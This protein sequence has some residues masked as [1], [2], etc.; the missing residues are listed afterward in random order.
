MQQ[1]PR[2]STRRSRRASLA[3][4]VA[5]VTAFGTAGLAM[6][7][8][9]GAATPLRRRRGRTGGGDRAGSPR[10]HVPLRPGPQGLPRHRPEPHLE[11]LVH[12]RGRRPVGRVLPDRGQHQR[13]DAAVRRHRRLDVH[14]RPDPRHDVHRP[15]PRP[16]RHG[17]PRRQH[18]EERPLPPRHRLHHRPT[19]EQRG[20]AD[21]APPREPPRPAGRLRPVRRD[22]QRQR[23]RRGP[24]HAERRRGHGSRRH[25]HRAP[26]ARLVRHQDRDDRGQP[27]LR[28][29]GVRRPPGG[30]AVLHR[31]ERFRGHRERRP[32]PARLRPRPG[33]DVRDGSAGERRPDRE[34]GC[35]ARA[36]VPARPGLLLDAARRRPHRRRER[37]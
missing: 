30:P 35:P 1:R 2:T 8:A 15:V 33:P 25:L 29:A 11:G 26:R 36:S 32:R 34:G 14:G 22:D 37:R 13:R 24:G 12:G 5:T 20:D 7:P 31:V 17:V 16:Q 10:R 18:G 28:P 9:A 19:A 27:R 3:A 23:R 6:A 4:L 21:D